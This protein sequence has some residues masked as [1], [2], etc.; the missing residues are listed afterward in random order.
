MEESGFLD[1][2]DWVDLFNEAYT[3]LYDLLL[4]TGGHYASTVST[5][6]VSAGT[7]EYDLPSDFYKLEWADFQV[8]SGGNIYVPLRRFTEQERNNTVGNV[9]N[10]PNGTVR[11]RYYPKPTKWTT[12]D[13]ATNIDGVAGYEKYI[14][15]AMAKMAKDIEET[16]SSK[17]TQWLMKYE[18]GIREAAMERDRHMPGRVQDVYAV[19][20]TV[21]F[22]SMR[23]NI[24]A[25]KIRFLSTVYVGI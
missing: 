12:G 3:D 16:D 22:P 10:I 15:T 4:M 2:Q 21:Y 25:D 1:T 13:V 23:Y 24:Y 18:E 11:I 7:E 5:I 14:V 8:G 20:N 17:E 9:D 6:A 19:D